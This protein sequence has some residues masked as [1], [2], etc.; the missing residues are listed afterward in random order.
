LIQQAEAMK[1]WLTIASG[2]NCDTLDVCGLFDARDRRQ[3]VP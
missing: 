3:A 1:A 2:C